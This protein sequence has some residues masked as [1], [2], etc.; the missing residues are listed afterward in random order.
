MREL[1]F[2]FNIDGIWI[3]FIIHTYEGYVSIFASTKYDCKGIALPTEY[4]IQLKEHCKSNGFT[5]KESCKE[6]IKR[7]REGSY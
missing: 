6:D 4:L 2:K 1:S 7:I 3:F 5:I